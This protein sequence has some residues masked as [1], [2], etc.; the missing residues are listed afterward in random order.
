LLKRGI[1]LLLVACLATGTVWAASDPLVGKWKLNPSMSKITDLMRVAAAGENKY[2]LIFNT[3]D[4]EP[5]VA[6]GTD[7][8]ASFGSTVSIT[9]AGPDSW[10]VVRKKNGKTQLTGNWTLSADGKTLTDHFS[11]NNADGST[12]TVDYIY[13][14]TAGG[15]GFPGTWE[16]ASDTVNYAF[17]LKIEPYEG[18]GLAFINPAGLTKNVKF[19]GKEYPSEGQYAAPGS[20]SSVRRVNEH[21]V[22]LTE[23]INGRIVDTQQIELSPDLKTLTITSHPSGQSKPNVLVFD[24]E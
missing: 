14:R 23:K 10:K 16:S 18:D 2:V 24:R 6:D 11:S 8:P 1:Q 15:P 20:V 21:T 22:E 9:V 4:G 7:Q 3:G 17:E 5:V 12:S 13:L 19:D